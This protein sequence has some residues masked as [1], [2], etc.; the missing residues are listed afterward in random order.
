VDDWKQILAIVVPLLMNWWEVR[1]LR[2]EIVALEERHLVHIVDLKA[3]QAALDI[4]L[5]ALEKRL[6]PA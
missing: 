2:K 1:K 6:V 5:T 3:G 4:R